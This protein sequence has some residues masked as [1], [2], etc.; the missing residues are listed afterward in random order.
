MSVGRMQVPVAVAAGIICFVNGAG[1]GVLAMLLFG[2]SLD[3]PQAEDSARGPQAMGG[4]MGQGMM[5]RGGGGP[6]GMGGMPRMPGGQGMFGRPNPKNQLALL[7][8]KLDQLVEKPLTLH[9]SPEQCTKLQD[10]L[11][12]LDE[13]K[14]LTNKEAQKR[15]NALLKIVKEQK[16]TLEA[17]G[18]RWPG[19]GPGGQ[20]PAP[21]PNPFKEK[22]N[23]KHLQDLQERLADK[24][25]A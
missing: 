16:A 7:V 1:G 20:P 21:A 6:R 25:K 10:Q 11:K 9:L 19:E 23:G 2:Y 17:A 22:A 24:L 8:V 13:K 3:K 5:R 14:D 15:L 12:G 18:Y 4:P